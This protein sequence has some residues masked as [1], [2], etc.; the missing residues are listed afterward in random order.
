MNEIDRQQLSVGFV[1]GGNMAQ[2]IIAGL[3]RAG[4]D[5]NQIR[6]GDPDQSQH[7]QINRLAPGAQVS[8]ENEPSLTAS[9]CVVAVKP[10]QVQQVLSGLTSMGG[11]GSQLFIS[12]AAGCTLGAMRAWLGHGPVLIR[13]MPNQPALVGQGMTALVGEPGLDTQAREI[14]SYVMEATGEILWLNDE[15]LMD[16]ATAISGSGPAY[17]YLLMEVLENTARE[18]GF[19]PVSARQLTRQTAA[20]AAACALDES[21]DVAELRHRVTSPGGTTEAALKTMQQGNLTGIVAN[22]LEAA[23]LRA[24]ELGQET[25]SAVHNSE[26]D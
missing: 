21:G 23:R 9:V 11:A 18:M 26:E 6:V 8:T 20:G 15:T 25:T 22:A 1:G 16:A 13:A 12:V 17:F 14:S 10:Q 7:A 2:A 24:A 5:P 4:H 3:V 19:D